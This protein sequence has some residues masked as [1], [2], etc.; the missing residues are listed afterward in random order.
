MECRNVNSHFPQRESNSKVN[1]QLPLPDIW[2]IMYKVPSVL[3]AI[4]S[5]SIFKVYI[6]WRFKRAPDKGMDM[7]QPSLGY[8]SKK[9]HWPS[10]QLCF[11]LHRKDKSSEQRGGKN[12]TRLENIMAS[13]VAEPTA[14]LSSNEPYPYNV[15]MMWCFWFVLLIFLFFSFGF[16]LNLVFPSVGAESGCNLW[17]SRWWCTIRRCS[18]WIFL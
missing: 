1:N 7:P 15:Q 14:H 5:A 6:A 13:M 2:H 3:E 10:D 18:L 4:S 8:I 11:I 9:R 16:F 12:P 17:G